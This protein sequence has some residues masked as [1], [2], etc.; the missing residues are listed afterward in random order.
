MP[1]GFRDRIG[2]YIVKKALYDVAVDVFKD[3]H[4][5]FV[6][7]WGS[8]RRGVLPSD[9]YVEWFGGD[10]TQTPGPIGR[11]RSR[12]ET[13]SIESIWWSI[14]RG[15]VDA[16]REAEEYLYDRL[17][18]LERHVRYTDPNLGGVALS[19]ALTRAVVETAD[20]SS[21]INQVG[22]LAAA[23]VTFE[24]KIRITG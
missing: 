2:L 1:T 19:C 21:T 12:D 6:Q 3:D 8:V 23:G 18:E 11:N 24:A 14:V 22:F 5:E 16:A 15:D 10:A 9:Q 4:P 17:G 13:V 20:A 7:V